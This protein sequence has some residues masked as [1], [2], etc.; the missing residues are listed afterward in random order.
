MRRREIGDDEPTVTADRSVWQ[1]SDGL[2][3]HGAPAD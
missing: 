1:V 3:I 2:P